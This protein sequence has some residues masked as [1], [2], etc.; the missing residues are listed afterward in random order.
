MSSVRYPFGTSSSPVG[1]Y[2]REE[3][4]DPRPMNIHEYQAK[5]AFRAAGIPVPPGDVTDTP[6][7]AESLARRFGGTVVVKAQVHSGGRGKAG[8]VK[9]A[10]SPEEARA[11]AGAILG[12]RI[13]GLTVHKVLVT[14]AEEIASEAYVGL[15]IDR[16]SQ[17]TTLMVSSEGGVDIEEVARTQPEAIRRLRVDPRYGLLPHQA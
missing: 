5:E 2:G 16:A 6:E 15:L 3:N 8:G 11:H 10:S 17:A 14:P 7:G 13:S 4:H 12:M 1:R 9:L